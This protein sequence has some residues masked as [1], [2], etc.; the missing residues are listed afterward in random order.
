MSAS[1]WSGGSTTQLFIHPPGSGYAAR[2]F[3]VRVSSAT[4]EEQSSV[5]TSLP[6]YYRIL[7]PLSAPLRLVYQDHGEVFVN[8]LEAVEFEG[9]WHTVS[10]GVCTDLGVMLA[11]GWHG[12][13]EPARSGVYKGCPG[14]MGVY[15]M[16]DRI[17]FSAKENDESLSDTLMQGDFLLLESQA[18][19][20]LALESPS[21]NAAVLIRVFK[22]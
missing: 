2:D 4:V 17:K 11:A 1:I 13:L 12:S 7:M 10:H 6:G 8:P 22:L 15:A 18:A 20:R 9:E 16:A 3:E 5:F 19:V 14:F 21:A